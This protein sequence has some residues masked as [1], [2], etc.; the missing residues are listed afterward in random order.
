[1]QEEPTSPKGN[2][3]IEAESAAEMARLNKQDRFLTQAMGGLLAERSDVEQMHNILDLGCGPGQWVLDLA[4]T[5][6][7]IEVAGIDI[8]EIMVQYAHASARVQGLTNASFETMDITK[9][10]NFPDNAFDLVNGRFLA[11]LTPEQWGSLI[12]ECTRILRPGG[13]LRLTENEFVTTSPATDTLFSFFYRAMSQ[14]GQSFSPTGRVLGIT[15][16]LGYMLRHAGY[17][18]VQ[19]KASAVDFSAGTASHE[20]M[21]DVTYVFL[22]LMQ[23]FL[24]KVG[25][26]TQDEMERLLNQMQIEMRSDDFCAVLFMLTAWGEK[27]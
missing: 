25:V 23:P 6:P 18:N 17:S 27:P 8:S 3:F 5:Y 15:P 19:Y 9:P 16:R 21:C 10:L 20:A 7:H 14:T 11:F 1:M 4:Y 22:T 26:T 12:G 2:Y 13:V 24:I